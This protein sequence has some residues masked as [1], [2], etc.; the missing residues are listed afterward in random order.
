MKLIGFGQNKTRELVRRE[1]KT[2]NMPGVY[3]KSKN[4]TK[5]NTFLDE[6]TDQKYKNISI[7]AIK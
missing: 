1:Y 3:D 7:K 2:F 5:L 4:Y 6:Q